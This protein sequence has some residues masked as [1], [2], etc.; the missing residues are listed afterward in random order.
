MLF[1]KYLLVTGAIGLFVSA[2]A[3]VILDLYRAFRAPGAAAPVRWR[4]A[5]SLAALGWLSLLPALSVVVV[6]S[7]MAGVRVSQI[8]GTLGGTLYPGTHFVVPFVQHVK[9]FNVRDQI[10]S[11]DASEPAKDAKPGT[12]LPVLK[13]YSKEGLPVGLGVSVR[14][15]LD[16]RKL[17]GIESSLPLPVET[18]LMPPVVANAFR[19]TI[20][21]YMVRDVFSTRREE[22][23][24]LAAESITPRLAADGIIV[25]EVM[26][27]DLVLPPEY[28]K[29]LE[30]LLVKAQENDRMSIEIELKQKMVRTAELEADA[31]KVRQL[32]QAEA[33]ATA[34]VLE[35]KAQADAMQH[36]LPLKEKQIQQTRLE[37]EARKEST[38]KNAEAA[39]QAKVIDSRAELE[40]RNLLSQAEAQ[41]IRVLA[42][43]DAERMRAEASVLQ[44]NPLL[45]QKIIAERL[46]DKVQIMM[47]PMDGKFFFANDVLKTQSPAGQAISLSLQ[48]DR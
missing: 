10:F 9:L 8:S 48:N 36:T 23:R 43:A 11:T 45:I 41:R 21:N 37:A 7:G 31:D 13:V 12:A 35:A 44:N 30:G 25:K 28:A 3:I 46:S 17:P 1:V 33:R 22:V 5:G 15:Q 6:P 24:R 42:I 40:K 47:V 32:K 38:V 34:T 39:A 2:A 26:M 29:A 14:Y 20:S 18:E 19:Q 16:P 27:R 4:L